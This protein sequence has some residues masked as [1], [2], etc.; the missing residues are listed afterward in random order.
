MCYTLELNVYVCII[1][2]PFEPAFQNNQLLAP[3]IPDKRTPALPQEQFFVLS[4]VL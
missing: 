1:L 4:L 3:V 2:S